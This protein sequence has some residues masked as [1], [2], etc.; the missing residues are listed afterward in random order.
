MIFLQ[1]SILD[2]LLDEKSGDQ[3][4]SLPQTA[5]NRISGVPEGSSSCPADSTKDVICIEGPVKV[6]KDRIKKDNH[7]KSEY[8]KNS[9][10]FQTRTF[11]FR[12]KGYKLQY[13]FHIISVERK[14]RF[15]IND[16]ITEQG[17]LLP[18]PNERYKK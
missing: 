15:H 2:L 17:K 18:R 8:Y 9:Y 13:F 12:H 14:R 3:V 4:A 7:N 5:F 1:D 11:H 6:S 16:M 10:I